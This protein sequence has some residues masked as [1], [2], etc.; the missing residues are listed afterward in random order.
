MTAARAQTRRRR[1]PLASIRRH[2]LD[3]TIPIQKQV[4]VY[5]RI[6]A[7]PSDGMLLTKEG[8]GG[9]PAVRV[10]DVGGALYLMADGDVYRG[11]RAAGA[12]SV[13]C[14]VIKC[15]D[16][17]DFLVRH[18]QHN[19]RPVGTNPILLRRVSDYV[20]EHG[21][22]EAAEALSRLYEGTVHQKFLTLDLDPEAGRILG[23]L[24][25]FLG[26]RL[27]QFVLP[28]YIPHHVSTH[29]PDVQG[30]IAGRISG[31]VRTRTVT[32]ARFAWPSPEEIRMLSSSPQYRKDGEEPAVILPEGEHADP[33]EIRL[34]HQLIRNARDV[35]V[36]PGT[37]KHPPYMI[38]LKT[39]RVS[40]VEDRES[41][42]VLRDAGSEGAGATTYLLPQKAGAWL[43]LAG[44]G[45]ESA[46]GIEMAQFEGATGGLAEFAQRHRDA[47][48]VVLYRRPGNGAGR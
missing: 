11:A 32:D 37:D 28:Y 7:G 19:H 41:V 18:V 1:V 12:E 33:R 46:A 34:A 48:A 30:E 9:M 21:S 45:K 8:V 10:G 42:V 44:G 14:A 40:E 20:S 35:I 4:E 3:V 25:E 16:E 15:A 29:R 24:C 31:L 38:D 17:S 23:G 22:R 2:E 26:A 6:F 43:G 5:R 27:S 47:R 13:T 39:K 36:I